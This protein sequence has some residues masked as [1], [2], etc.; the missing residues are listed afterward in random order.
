MSKT[1]DISV[2]MFKASLL[3]IPILLIIIAALIPLYIYL[4]GVMNLFFAARKIV[5][6]WWLFLPVVIVCIFL[7]EV[8]HAMVFSIL[9]DE[10]F[11]YVRI[12]IQWDTITPYA[13]YSKPIQ[14]IY[15]RIAL[16]APALILGALPIA[17]GFLFQ[18]G[19]LFIF[20]LLFLLFSGGDLLILWLIRMV[21][22]KSCV[23]DH[24]TRA[25]CYVYED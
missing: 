22:N 10:G 18:Q 5:F 7:H 17:L 23:K 24:P 21:P 1:K 20:G 8:V 14:A 15:Y 3:C 2:G 13:H 9:G 25:G 4:Y 11:K 6:R 12:G 16:L 19:I